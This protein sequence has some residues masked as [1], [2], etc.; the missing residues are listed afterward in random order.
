MSFSNQNRKSIAFN[1]K[2]LYFS[3]K[4]SFSHYIQLKKEKVIQTF[5]LKWY[6]LKIQKI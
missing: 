4:N 5:F 2:K 3:H 1:F 6:L